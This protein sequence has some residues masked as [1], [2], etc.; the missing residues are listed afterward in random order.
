M[1]AGTRNRARAYPGKRPPRTIPFAPP[2]LW[3]TTVEHWDTIAAW[4]DGLIAGRDGLGA[5]LTAQV[6][7]WT[8]GVDDPK[9]IL[10]IL[11]EKAAN[12]VRYT[13]LEFGLAG[14]QPY[15]CETVWKNRYGD[16]KDKANLLR[17]MLRH[18]GIPAHMVLLKSGGHGDVEKRNPSWHQFNHAIT[19][20]ELTPGEF[21]FCDPTIERLPAGKVGIGDAER[22]V[23]IVKDG[24]AVWARTPDTSDSVIRLEIDA[25]MDATGAIRGWFTLH[26]E[27]ADAA[28]HSNYY[29]E[30]DDH[31]RRRT[32]Q[33]TLDDFFPGA[34]VIDA[35]FDVPE[36]SVLTFEMRTYFV[37]PGTGNRV[38]H[39]RFSL[40]LGLAAQFIARM[41]NATG[42]TTSDVDLRPSRRPFACP[43][44]MTA[45]KLPT[46]FA[47][48]AEHSQFHASWDIEEGAL[49]ASLAYAPK[50]R[51]FDPVQ[52]AEFHRAVRALATWLEAPVTIVEGDGG[53]VIARTLPALEDFPILSDAA[54]QLRL[55]DKRFPADNGKE[56]R[57]HA[58]EKIAQWF[59]D[60]RKRCL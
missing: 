49:K 55:V 41:P 39:R 15:P 10:D 1:Q 30:K 46:P 42:P 21:T 56:E 35:K 25:E 28:S 27:G 29:A 7:A 40:S 54:A 8:D 3:L 4:F 22:D 19:A 52:Y 9:D 18:K 13:G 2:T 50:Q 48:A 12:E 31:D 37:R 20:V 23:L 26:G 32:M 51:I 6:D 59:P 43:K 36:G 57:R 14:Y 34:E 44:N 47:T 53:A 5:A 17:A 60:G 16:C 38:A 58:L 11:T 45:E 24:K 33:N